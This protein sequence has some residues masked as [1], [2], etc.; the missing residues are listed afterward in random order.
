MIRCTRTDFTHFNSTVSESLPDS[1]LIISPYCQPGPFGFCSG[2]G[3]SIALLSILAIVP[4]WTIWWC[5]GF[6]LTGYSHHTDL[7]EHMRKLCFQP[8]MRRYITVSRHTHAGVNLLRAHSFLLSLLRR[9]QRQLRCLYTS[10]DNTQATTTTKYQTYTNELNEFKP[11]LPH[12]S[13]PF[14]IRV[15]SG[16]DFRLGWK[17]CDVLDWWEWEGLRR[18]SSRLWSRKTT[19]FA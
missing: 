11:F 7:I 13:L 19:H 15:L 2:Q 12:Q 3:H 6:L 5:I 14:K 17:R 18:W 16:N 10:E 8:V 4:L 9:R 1:L